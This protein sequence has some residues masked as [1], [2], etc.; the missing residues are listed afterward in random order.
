MM[1]AFG[2]LGALREPVMHTLPDGQTISISPEDCYRCSDTRFN[3]ESPEL[4]PPPRDTVFNAG[5]HALTW[6]AISKCHPELKQDL[7]SHVV[8]AGGNTMFPGTGA[9][10]QRELKLLVTAGTKV[11]VREPENRLQSAWIGG[12]VFASQGTF[13]GSSCSRAQYEEEGSSAMHR[14]CC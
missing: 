7:W 11:E 4:L 6:K 14:K 8:L 5:M 2:S 3:P 13:E 9:K 12:S 1:G 10:L